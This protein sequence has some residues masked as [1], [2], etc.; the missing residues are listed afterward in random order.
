MK[1]FDPT[2]RTCIC[3]DFLKADIGYWPWQKYCDCVSLKP[4]C[5]TSGWKI[6]LA[7]SRFVRDNEKRYALIEG[8]ALGI[9][10]ALEDSKYFTFGCDDLIVTTD[11]K[12]LTKIFGGRAL[13]HSSQKKTLVRKT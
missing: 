9:A 1:I 11:H 8:E 10:W 5:C 6:T 13:D 3:S 2:R 4:D 12:P 7:G